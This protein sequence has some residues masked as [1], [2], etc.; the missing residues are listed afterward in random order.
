SKSFSS[1]PSC[2]WLQFV[3][4]SIAPPPLDRSS[5]AL[6]LTVSISSESFLDSEVSIFKRGSSLSVSFLVKESSS[7]FSVFSTAASVKS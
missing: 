4:E 3:L 6:W 1:S 7:V 2:P 5:S